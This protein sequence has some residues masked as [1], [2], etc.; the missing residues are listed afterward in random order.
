MS[1]NY[2]NKYRNL[3]QNTSD[4]AKQQSEGLSDTSSLLKKYKVDTS[5]ESC[6]KTANEPGNVKLS[7]GFL[8]PYCVYSSKHD[9]IF[10]FG[11]G[12]NPTCCSI[13]IKTNTVVFKN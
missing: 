12:D 9:K 7:H 8:C 4:G 5:V 3:H 2:Y 10:I 1:R 6:S 13:N 11:S